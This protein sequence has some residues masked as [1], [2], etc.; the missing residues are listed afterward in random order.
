VALGEGCFCTNDFPRKDTTMAK[1]SIAL[2]ELVEKIRCR[3]S[4]A[5]VVRVERFA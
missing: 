4:S 2:A 3:R 5:G 1:A